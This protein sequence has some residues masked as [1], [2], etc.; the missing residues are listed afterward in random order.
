MGVTSGT[1]PRATAHLIRRTARPALALLL[2]ACAATAV[3]ADDPPPVKSKPAPPAQKREE[4]VLHCTA[5]KDLPRQKFTF[6]G[7][8]W[9][10]ELCF[11]DTTRAI[12]MG[13]REEFP[14]GTAMIFV[15][16]RAQ[17]LS[18][19]M[20]DCFIDL[21]MVF[22]D[23]DGKICAT[24]AAKKQL[25]RSKGQTLEGYEAGLVRYG[26]NRRAKYCIELPAGTV[27]RLKPTL[28]QKIDI[29]WASLDKRA[30]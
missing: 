21:D 5:Q 30:K 27:A 26:S 10:C 6:F 17:M 3:A 8:E 19:W 1:I 24:H 14:A 7:E 18:F 20:K 23:G 9:N 15:Y 22:V 4:A 12:G 25:L 16:P 28:G 2:C 29:D 13:A 11:D